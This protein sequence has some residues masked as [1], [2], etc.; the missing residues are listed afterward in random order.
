M[1]IFFFTFNL[2]FCS[3]SISYMFKSFVVQALLLH[4]INQAIILYFS[5][6]RFFLHTR[7]FTLPPYSASQH[8]LSGLLWVH[9]CTVLYRPAPGR[10]HPQ[11]HGQHRRLWP[12][13]GSTN[14]DLPVPTISCGVQ[15]W[16]RTNFQHWSNLLNKVWFYLPPSL[17]LWSMK[18][19]VHA[20]RIDFYNLI[21]FLFINFLRKNKT[22]FIV[23]VYMN[24]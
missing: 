20:L 5:L 17:S 1:I 2:S 4:H 22:V 8:Q 16:R 9:C 24:A 19:T 11:L 18:T 7:C 3:I 6:N 10:P 12:L 13:P 15:V 23:Y 14:R 21:L